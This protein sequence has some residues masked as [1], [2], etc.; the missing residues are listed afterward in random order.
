MEISIRGAEPS[1]LDA[2]HAIFNGEQIIRGTLRMP[3]SSLDSMGTRLNADNNS[4]RYVAEVDD[5]VV[6]FAEIQTYPYPR[7]RHVAHL[8]MITVRDDMQGKGIGSAL[9][10]VCIDIADNYLLARRF[11]LEVWAESPAVK[12]Y[13]KY[14]FAI[15]GKHIDFGVRDGQYADMYTMARIRR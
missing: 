3:Y 1:D 15:E 12:L 8:N 4:Y 11:Y 13:E 10:D 5:Q 7:L 6:G 14:G 9:L 2:V